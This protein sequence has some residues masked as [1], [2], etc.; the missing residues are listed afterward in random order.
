MTKYLFFSSIDE[1]GK[2]DIEYLV[3]RFHSFFAEGH[4]NAYQEFIGEQREI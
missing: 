4:R 3:I 1:K 2:E